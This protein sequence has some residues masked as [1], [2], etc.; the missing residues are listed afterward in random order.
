MVGDYQPNVYGRNYDFIT[1][2]A[3]RKETKTVYNMKMFDQS[4]CNTLPA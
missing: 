2:A 4:H 1:D 3:E